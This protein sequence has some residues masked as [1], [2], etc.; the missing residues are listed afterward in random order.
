MAIEPEE[1]DLRFFVGEELMARNNRPTWPI[2]FSGP[3]SWRGRDSVDG[4]IR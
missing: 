2:P 3:G 4:E 1:F